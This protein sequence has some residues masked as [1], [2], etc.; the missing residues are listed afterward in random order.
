MSIHKAFQY[1]FT[2]KRYNLNFKSYINI[3]C[4][5]S[6]IQSKF[7]TS[8]IYFCQKF[9]L[10]INITNDTKSEVIAIIQNYEKLIEE[11]S[12]DAEKQKS[13]S[14][15][16]KND[17]YKKLEVFVNTTTYGSDLFDVAQKE[18]FNVLNNEC[19]PKFLSLFWDSDV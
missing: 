9:C 14:P 19:L 12:Y 11:G 5:E 15:E 18:A 1:N 17:W 3:I 4:K 7:T 13:M 10:Q 16:Q 2:T 8:L 6:L